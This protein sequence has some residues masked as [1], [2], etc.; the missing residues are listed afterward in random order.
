[1]G[2][3]KDKEITYQLPS[4]AKQTQLGEVSL[5]DHQSRQTKIMRIKTKS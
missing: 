4:R 3:D 5:T 1:M 2:Q